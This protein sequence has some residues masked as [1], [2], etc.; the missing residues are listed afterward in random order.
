MKIYKILTDSSICPKIFQ[1]DKIRY[2]DSSFNALELGTNLI[3]NKFRCHANHYIPN[4][5]YLNDSILICSER[6]LDL[7]K[8]FFEMSSEIITI[9]VNDLVAYIINVLDVI[10]GLDKQ[11]NIWMENKISKYYFRESRIGNESTIFKIPDDEYSNIFCYTK[12][13]DADDEFYHFYKNNYLP[14]LMFEL[15][16]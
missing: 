8:G 4:F 1:H 10:N 3:N 7:Y 16:N 9:K 13:E 2:Q 5:Y 15:L 11:K 6:A 14:G 12:S